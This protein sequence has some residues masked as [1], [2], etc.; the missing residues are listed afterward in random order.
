VKTE[1]N[2]KI[3]GSD[4]EPCL[5]K[6]LQAERGISRAE[7]LQCCLTCPYSLSMCAYPLSTLHR[8]PGCYLLFLCYCKGTYKCWWYTGSCRMNC[9]ETGLAVFHRSKYLATEQSM[10]LVCVCV[11]VYLCVC[12]SYICVHL[13]VFYVFFCVSLCVI[14]CVFVYVS[15][16]QY[17]FVSVYLWVCVCMY[18]CLCVAL[19]VHLYICVH[20]CVLCLSV[21]SLCV[22]MCI[23][24]YVCMCLCVCD[25]V[26]VSVSV[27]ICD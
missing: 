18:A 5:G 22:S 19:S 3:T 1:I 11:S 17:V 16:C 10:C 14:M 6:C 8:H 25:C 27:C 7:Y 4:S 24:V 15:M 26:C 21:V 2:S 20:L 12:V 23:S 13:R 9:G